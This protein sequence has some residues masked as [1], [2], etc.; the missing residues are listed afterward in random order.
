MARAW[1]DAGPD[2]AAIGGPVRPAFLAPRPTWLSDDL[3]GS[4]SII[5][6]GSRPRVLT[7][8]TGFL[9]TANLSF[10]AQH[11][12]SAGGFNPTL[13]PLGDVPGFGDD[14]DI[15]L[16]LIRSGLRVL[17]QPEVAVH[18]RIPSER[19]SRRALLQRQYAHG[20]YR[21][22]ATAGPRLMIATRGLVAGLTRATAYT[23]SGQSASAM[24][25]LAYG[26][27]CVGILRECIQRQALGPAAHFSS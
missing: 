18:H 22:R 6:H 21:A 4:L 16:R 26:V 15:Q 19:L 2:I 3:L 5:D 13:G 27:Q 23:C 17:Y 12:L 8:T 14:I 1:S 10:L 9:Y 7:E 24:D 11:A 20:R 25:H